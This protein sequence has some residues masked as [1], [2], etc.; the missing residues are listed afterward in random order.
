MVHL[1]LRKQNKE[2]KEVNER[3]EKLAK[4]KDEF[5][6]NVSH[7][8]RTPLNA[9]G[10]YAEI[11]LK[12]DLDTDQKEAVSIIK[13][14]CEILISLINDILDFSKI[15]LGK[16]QLEN[17]PFDLRK[18]IK[19]VKDLLNPKAK[20]KNLKFDLKVEEK[21]PKF[22]LGDKVRINQIIMN[23]TGNALKFT[24]EGYVKIDIKLLDETE[25]NLNI[26]FSVKDSGIGIQENKLKTVFERFEQ[27]GKD[28]TRKFGGS[29]L[30]LNISR[31]L[32]ELH[33]S[34]LEIESVF[35]KGTEFFFT[36][37]FDKFLD[38]EDCKFY[39]NQKVDINYMEKISNTQ[40]L[41]LLVCEDNL[42]NIKL[43]KAIF[44]NKNI[45][46][47]IAENGKIAI[48]FLK[49]KKKFDLILMDLQ[50]PEMNGYETT[51]YIRN[52]MNLNI[53]IIGFSA[54]TSEIERNYCFEV[55]MND[56]IL[57]SFGGNEI[58]DKLDNFVNANK[59]Y[60]EDINNNTNNDNNN[61]KKNNSGSN[62]FN[63]GMSK[64]NVHQKIIKSGNSFKI[65]K[66]FK[67]KFEANINNDTNNFNN[68]ETYGLRGIGLLREKNYSNS[69]KISKYNLISHSPLT[70][71]VR[72]KNSIINRLDSNRAS[73]DSN[74]RSIFSQKIPLLRN[75]NINFSSEVNNRT[76]S[77]NSSKYIRKEKF[78]INKKKKFY[79]NNKENE[80]YFNEFNIFNNGF[81]T[82]TESNLVERKLN[83]SFSN[84]GHKRSKKRLMKKIDSDKTSKVDLN[85][86]YLNRSSQSE[87]NIDKYNI[88]LKKCI[89]V[90]LKEKPSKND[91]IS[92]ANNNKYKFSKF[93]EN[94]NTS[95]VTSRNISK[96]HSEKNNAE[97]N[98]NIGVHSLNIN[99]NYELCDEKTEK[100]DKYTK[101][102]LED[103]KFLGNENNFEII[104]NNSKTPP[105]IK[106]N[107]RN[108]K[109]EANKQIQETEEKFN[110]IKEKN[111]FYPESS[112]SKLKDNE[113]LEFSQVAIKFENFEDN[114]EIDNEDMINFGDNNNDMVDNFQ[115][116]PE[117]RNELLELFLEE[118][119]KQLKSLKSAITSRNLDGIKFFAHTMKP[120]VLMFGLRKLYKMLEKI[121][122]ISK[123]ISL[124][125][126]RGL[127]DEIKKDLQSFYFENKICR[128]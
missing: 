50:M 78:S 75:Y 65:D 21:I 58:F 19:N 71:I 48:E 87:R 84:I 23:L 127:Y 98:L 59:I 116:D 15:Q 77:K 16:L 125:K 1:E 5:L 108:L 18:T 73:S 103:V 99:F 101:K 66:N 63:R 57:K 41:K 76:S 72:N 38:Q 10:G 14:S 13:S 52:I 9:I 3:A 95:K 104:S 105:K 49:K 61:D 67:R 90:G 119:P 118:N 117:M 113:S 106:E 55:G 47:E 122:V 74:H 22:I 42:V 17:I 30:G 126:V 114:S 36:I 53:P 64:S 33:N 80:E 25:K 69:E 68:Y 27:A 45:N 2:L 93:N 92:T 56:Y 120:S 60:E 123:S 6:N 26:L 97:N 110:L 81:G 111:N 89:S 85:N 124:S 7:E 91:L 86:L 37:Q 8:L 51:K 28:I 112:F 46:I 11:L 94:I 62:K 100:N 109:K 54:S 83:L 88:H 128:S 96:C 39:A 24:Q 20:Q 70:S 34:K 35:G 32:V 102:N 40:Y 31:N 29:G 107:I 12:T 82:N 43:I 44:K 115:D 79:E 4:V 121:E